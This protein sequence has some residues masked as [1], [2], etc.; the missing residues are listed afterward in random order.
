MPTTNVT[1]NTIS[2]TQQAQQAFLTAVGDLNSILNSVTDSGTQ[3]T[4]SAMVSQ[5]GTAFGG[6]VMRWT[7]DF[8]DLRGTLQWMA[9][10]LEVQWRQMQANEA[11]NVDLASGLSLPV[12]MPVFGSFQGS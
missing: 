7:E 1:Q 12:G 2:V 9:D 3:L 10:Q 5:A 8:N 6:A 11:N 4:S